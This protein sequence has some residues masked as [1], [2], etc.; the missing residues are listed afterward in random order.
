[1]TMLGLGTYAVAWAIGVPG[2]EQPR[3]PLDA[4]GVL[5]CADEL[6]LRLVQ[7]ADNL[8]LHPLTESQLMAIRDEAQRRRIALEVGTRG[9][10]TA[11]LHRYIEIATLLGSPILRVIIDTPDHHPSP[12]EVVAL[13]EAALPA[14]QAHHVTLAIENHDR[15]RTKVL[16]GIIERL[17][18]PHVGI[19]LDT[20]NSFGAL[21]GPEVVVETLGRY[22]V[23]L[24]LKEFIVKRAG[25]AMGFEITGRPAGQ[26]ML[27]IPWLLGKLDSFGRSYNTILETWLPMQAT[28]EETAAMEM[29]WARQGVQYMRQF[30]RD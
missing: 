16:A 24:H 7:F 17:N 11:H 30:I 6:G 10:Q 2:Y 29:R 14:L 3:A 4:F 1:M 15:F 19:C 28:I 25:H 23:N 18:T 13:I 9:I 5:Q 8:A 26:G 12:D 22:A 21:E 27:D 20:V